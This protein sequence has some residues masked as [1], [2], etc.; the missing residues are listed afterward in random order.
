MGQSFEVSPGI[1]RIFLDAQ[2]LKFFDQQ[3]RISLFSRT[4]ATTTYD[5]TKTDL[6]T[7]G[8]VN[9]STASGV[10]GTVVGRISS[11]ATGVDVGVHFFKAK[12]AF[13]VF[14]LPSIQLQ[15]DLFYSWFSILRFT[16][17]I[18]DNWKMYNS[19]ELYSAFGS[20]GHL[21]SVQRIR[22]GMDRKGY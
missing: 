17:G 16:P 4:R 11:T 20:Q 12:R 19:L 2:F 18:N 6:F 7:G 21:A 5:G 10:G 1:N 8:Y 13:M 9:Y 22:V 3:S 15:K 14:A